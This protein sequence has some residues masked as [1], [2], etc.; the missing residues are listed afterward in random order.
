[1]YHNEQW[2]CQES[3]INKAIVDLR[4][5]SSHPTVPI[6][7]TVSLQS[8]PYI[9]FP[10]KPSNMYVQFHR[11]EEVTQRFICPT[12]TMINDYS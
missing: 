7:R 10:Y 4:N 3:E 12:N 2:A 9:P 6:H 11:S 1:M 5:H 8:Y